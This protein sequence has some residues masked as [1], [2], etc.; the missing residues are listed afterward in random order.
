MTPRLRTHRIY[1]IL[2]NIG[3]NIGQNI[4]NKNTSIFNNVE[5]SLPHGLFIGLYFTQSFLLNSNL[6]I[7]DIGIIAINLSSLFFYFFNHLTTSDEMFIIAIC[8]KLSFNNIHYIDCDLNWE[9]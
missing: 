1:R 9:I 3:Y 2:N 5:P 8:Y 7:E 6:H 4:F